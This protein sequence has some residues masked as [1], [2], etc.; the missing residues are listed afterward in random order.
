MQ[1]SG[2]A[3]LSRSKALRNASNTNENNFHFFHVAH[4]I[5]LDRLSTSINKK[6]RNRTQHVEANDQSSTHHSSSDLQALGSTSS[7]IRSNGTCLHL[8]FRIVMVAAVPSHQL[9]RDAHEMDV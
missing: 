4:Q 8:L 1:I 7:K 9:R 2:C 3:W 5:N 6:S